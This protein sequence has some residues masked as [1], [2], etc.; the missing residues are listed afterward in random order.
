MCAILVVQWL[1]NSNLTNQS[2]REGLYKP[3]KP[4]IKIRKKKRRIR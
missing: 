2:I 3:K 4:E 1:V